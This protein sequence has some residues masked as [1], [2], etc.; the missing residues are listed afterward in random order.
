VQLAEEK[1]EKAVRAAQTRGRDQRL[2][3]RWAA[4][5]AVSYA[6]DALFLALFAAAG[7]IG[8][9]VPLAYGAAATLICAM[10]WVLT[11]TNVNLRF[12]DPNLTAPLMAAAV[13]LQLAV[14]AMSPQIAFPFLANL[15]TVFAFGMLWMTP[16]QSIVVWTLGAVALAALDYAVGE[17]FGIPTATAY[18]RTLVWLYFSL[19]LGRCVLL[20][21]EASALR[22]RIE[23]GRHKLAESLDQ[24]RQLASH[25]ELTRTLNRRS[26]IARLEQ[27]R[28]RAERGGEGFSVALLDLDHFKDINDTHGHAVGDDVLRAFAK[29]AY[30]ALRDSD[31][32]GRHG[33]EEFMLILGA[34]APAAAHAALERLRAA[35]AARNWEEFAPGLHLTVSAGVAGFRR[36][37]TVSQ[38]L[39]RADGALYE[40]KHAG[41]NRTVVKE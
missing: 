28:S 6:A 15:F 33:G 36:G 5:T 31:A 25:D 16:R 37:E 9:V 3:L 14:V 30:G 7:T 24:M 38:L 22:R 13:L 26:L 23:E 27:E 12:R 41:R 2:R 19:I 40:A 1:L 34:T 17:R 35:V 32:F 39:S 21:V 8:G 18:E 10:T 4:A 11:A 20:S 29:M